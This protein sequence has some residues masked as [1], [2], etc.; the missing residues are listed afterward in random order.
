M[1]KR[2]LI[3]AVSVLV[4]LRAFA[5]ET[6]SDIAGQVLGDKK[7]LSGATVTAVHTPSGSSYKTTSRSDGR[8]NLPNVRVGGPYIITVSYVGFQSAS[9][10]SILLT[11]GQEY[12]ADFNLVPEVKQLNEVTVTTASSGG[13]VFNTSHTGNQE[14]ITRAQLERL[15]TVNRSLLDFTRL[16]PGAN[17]LSFGGQSNQYNNITVDGANFNNSFGLSGTLG[18]QTN[19]QPISTDALEQIQ[20]NVSPYDVRQGGFS[21][22]SIN[23]VTRSGTNQFRGSLYTYLKGPGTQGYKV[24]DITIPH[25]DF[26]YNLTGFSVGGPIIESKLFFFVSGEQE[27]RTD[28]GTSFV[29]SDG[30]NKPNG[31]SVSNA[32][33]DTLNALAS[34]L[35]SKYNYDPGAFQGY[36]YKTQSQKLT[37]KVDWN[38][39]QNNTLTVKYNF[40]KSSRQIQASNSGSVNSSYGRT[41][42]Q[43]AMPFFGSGYTINNNF[44][45]IIAELNTRFGNKASNKLQI[46]YTALRDF[47]SPLTSSPFPLVDI[48]DGSGNPYTSFG[49]E[50]FTYGNLLNTDVYQLNDVYTM[51]KGTHEITV[52]TQNSLKKYENGFS[53]A[54]EGVYRFSSLGAFYAAAADPAVKALRYDLSYT[55]PPN[56][57][58][59]LVGPQ[60][61]E[62]GFFAQDKWRATQNFTLIYGLRVDIP[63]FKN[64]FLQNDS[65]AALT[66]YD[67]IHLNTGQAPHVNPLFGPRIGFNWDVNGDQ[68]TQLRGGIGLFA[69]PPPFVWIS[70]Q[71][72][73]SGVALFGSISN[74]TTTS[75]SPDV[76]PNPNWPANATKSLSKS[77]SLNVT[78]P[79]FKF[80][81]ALKA[82][83][84]VDQKLPKNWIVT[85]E[86]TYAKDV[87]AAFFQNVNLPEPSAGTPLVGAD[88]RIRY[89]SSQ[90]YP[91]GGAAAATVSNP[92]IG[93]AIYM[94]NVNGGY[95]YTA[96][97]QVQKQFK[98]LYVNA[99]YTYAMAKDVMVGGSTAATMW[100]SK[101]ISGDPNQP[102]V[103][104]SNAYMPSHFIAS[105]SYIFRYGK[106]YA[107]TV[108]LIF[109]AAV[110]G[111][112]SYVYNGDLNND[113]QTSNDLLYIPTVA[114]Y[115]SG[116]YVTGNTGGL[117]KRTPD[118]VWYQINAYISQDRYLNSH[119]GKYAERNALIFPWYSRL[120]AHVAQDFYM[121]AGK[122]T[123]TIRLSVDIVNVGNMINSDWGVYRLPS[124]GTGSS[125]LA[126]GVPNV[127]NVGLISA[128]VV[129]NSPVYSFP[130][131][132]AP[133]AT[134]AGVPYTSSWKDDTSLASRWQMQFGIR[135]LFN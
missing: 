124:A 91:V 107:T 24:E 59:P 102:W 98:G 43:Y 22:A 58:F 13:K 87:N 31:V 104:N 46:G 49:Y 113:G 134:S 32:N 110:S 6:T 26:S 51:Y 75:F 4:M 62:L 21:G 18:G 27:K 54:Y 15:P 48:L 94:T 42:G 66:F 123:H 1:R 8:F 30:S 90:I 86:M 115:T 7:P 85:L 129:N 99:S 10:D 67:G 97:I 95:A 84:A 116:K 106:H 37:I 57:P 23:S 83:L 17:G 16:T 5:Q 96:T 74:S 92:N 72:S 34:F 76:N 53:P 101:P 56:G 79:S 133:T 119:R 2:V 88:N 14:I 38:I 121:K 112:G 41:P 47:R 114:D 35:K 63:I 130:Y 70:N 65:A 28:P 78:D 29:A 125:I 52:G 55:L 126:S 81:Q 36:S 69:G 80:P 25:Q 11:L 100:G 61:L 44:D 64:T 103:G 12:K 3:L 60:D 89:A 105:G 111:I 128:R 40:L 135:Y 20:V 33:A 118:E 39:D 108:G 50:Q 131:Q 71:A 19:S 122:N 93:N 109:E 127:I 117:D 120:D 77:Y 45:I 82:S 132:I 68:K 73:N 9:Q